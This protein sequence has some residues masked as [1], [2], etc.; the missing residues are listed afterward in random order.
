[1]S[2]GPAAVI[3]PQN[4]GAVQMM[5]SATEELVNLDDA[6]IRGGTAA[7]ATRPMRVVRTLGSLTATEMSTEVLECYLRDCSADPRFEVDVVRATSTRR[8]VFAY[9]P[10]W[11]RTI[12]GWAHH[13]RTR[14]NEM[15]D[16]R[17]SLRRVLSSSPYLIEKHHSFG[18]RT[19][20][21]PGLACD[22]LAAGDWSC[23]VAFQHVN[24]T[25]GGIRIGRFE[26]KRTSDSFRVVT[27][28]TDGEFGYRLPVRTASDIAV[29][30]H[31][32][33][34]YLAIRSGNAGQPV[35]VFVSRDAEPDT[36][37]PEAA[38]GAYSILGLEAVGTKVAGDNVVTLAR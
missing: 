9:H 11:E 6:A 4:P 34:W 18:V 31:D 32:E 24:D 33:H 7:Q 36:W 26:L 28:R 23:V 12:M 22:T 27:E 15:G 8:P 37:A 21:G 19:T 5:W 16:L 10:L 2:A 30:R 13:S 38:P 17:V 1:M 25:L 29:W 14:R 3:E 20:V 35:E